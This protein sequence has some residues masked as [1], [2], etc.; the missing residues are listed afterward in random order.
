MGPVIQ[1]RGVDGDVTIVAD[2]PRYQVS[3][4]LPGAVPLPVRTAQQQPSRL[5]LARHQVVPFTGRDAELEAVGSWMGDDGSVSVRLI[6]AAG[7]QGKTRLA[8]HVATQAHG[9]GWSTWRV[10]HSPEQHSSPQLNVPAGGGALVVVDYADRWPASDLRTLITDLHTVSLRTG[11]V[12]RVLLLARSAGFWW[13]ALRDRLDS[14]H[15][16]AADA[17]QLL[18]LDERTDRTALFDQAR[19]RFSAALDIAGTETLDVPDLTGPG[20]RQILAVH[21]AALVAVDAHGRGHA[22]PTQPHALSAYLLG[23]ERAHWYQLHARTED[24]RATSPEVMARAVYLAS[25]T[26]PV[27]RD[28]AAGILN[29]TGLTE[30]G[31]GTIIDDHRFCYPPDDPATVLQALRPD[32]LGEDLIALSIPGHPYTSGDDWTPDDWAAAAVPD[33]LGTAEPGAWT[34]AVV[35]VLVETARRWPHVA[36]NVLYPVVRQHPNLVLAAGGATLTRLAELPDADPAAL[37]AIEAHLPQD[38]HV[39]L[40]TAAAAIITALTTHRLATTSDSAYRAQLHTTHSRRLFNAGRRDEALTPAEEAVAIHRQLAKTNPAAYLPDLAMSLSNLGG[41]LSGLG[42]HDEALAPAAEAEAMYRRL[43]ESNPVASLPGLARSLS[44]L[45]VLL[46]ELGQHDEA[47][48]PA[49]DAVAK[50]RQ[51]AEINPT[52]YQPDLAMS[53]SNLSTLL[54]RLGRRNEALVAAGEAVATYR[55]LAETDPGAYLPQL[56]MSLNNLGTSLSALGKRDYALAASE[57]AV[58]IRRWLAEINPAAYLPDLATSLT[59]LGNRLSGLGRRDEALA[60]AEEAVAIRR[61][62]AEINPAAYL[63]DLAT[64]VHNLG[65]FLFDLGYRN[66]GLASTEEAATIRRRLAKANPAAYLPDLAMSL[67]NVGGQMSGLGRRDEALAPAAEAVAT[68]RR[69]A[70]SNP[71]AFLADLAMSLAN[72]G[73]ALSGLGRRVEAFALTEEAVVIRRRLV[74]INPAANLP[75]LATAV[76][77]LTAL[78]CELGRLEDALVPAEEAVTLYR[79]L[80]KANPT[81]YL[82]DLAMALANRGI[83]LGALGQ[84]DEALASTEEAV[85]IRR[86]L[87]EIN[88]AAYL[89]DLATSLNNLGAELSEQGR[90]TEALVPAEEAATLHRRLAETNPTAY[91]ADHAASAN[92]LGTLLLKSGRRDEAFVRNHEAARIYRQLAGVNPTAYLPDFAM[93]LVNLGTSLA[94]L[95]RRDDALASAE[96]SIEIRRRLVE[97]DPTAYLPDLAMSLV[98]YAWI[99]VKLRADLAAALAAI[100]EAIE[101]YKPLTERLPHVFTEQLSSAYRT[102]DDVLSGLGRLTEV[103]DLRRQTGSRSRE[104]LE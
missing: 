38:R 2:R 17:H 52:A 30:P 4:L 47:L 71:A 78:L 91:L 42:R 25:L 34:A 31:A 55:R 33:L 19:E 24:R 56:A 49:A 11:L 62:L 85:V 18:P 82:P 94:V 75:D 51:L 96:E 103:R 67:S 27:T 5:L 81:A 37:E 32:R 39:D 36:T 54:S 29:A 73:A 60:P 93:S 3:D 50:Y 13:S 92:N 90:W 79:Q 59:N 8:R 23:R 22:P 45:G 80:T 15:A 101:L 77:N 43:A 88:P 14:D 63:P 41:H 21:M 44:N 64:S 35:T 61:R 68:Y 40:D 69:L 20:F 100:T 95:G 57:E 83:T 102:L 9:A 53:L 26:G 74:E 99:C 87:A 6:H 97:T 7:G 48:P 46:S 65:T 12:L 70:E 84:R 104:S 76:N 89:P 58:T 72:L 28:D 98:A 66:D 10:V 1:I 16:I 86:R